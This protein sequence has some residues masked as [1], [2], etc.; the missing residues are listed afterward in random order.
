MKAPLVG[1][2][3]PYHQDQPAGF[4][5]A[6]GG[7]G[8]GVDGAGRVDGGE[9]LPALPPR[10]PQAGPLDPGAAGGWEAR[11]LAGEVTEDVPLV[12]PP[13]GC[14]IHHGWLLHASDVNRSRSAGGY[15]AHY[16]SSRCRYGPLP[17]PDLLRVSEAYPGGV[18]PRPAPA[19]GAPAGS[20]SASPVRQGGGATGSP[21]PCRR[22]WRR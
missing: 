7:P 3:Q 15:A 1:S 22:R 13:G 18:W 11:S 20:R 10:L 6:P 5:I 12:L 8:H 14:G 9:R 16:V 2:R 4:Y 21:A 19:G 17:A